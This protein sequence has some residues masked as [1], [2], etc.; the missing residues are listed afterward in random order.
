MSENQSHILN[1]IH[2]SLFLRSESINIIERIYLDLLGRSL[3][4]NGSAEPSNLFGLFT[5]GFID[6]SLRAARMI[7]F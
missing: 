6:W 7:A 4:V 1:D 2:G 3:I 5:D